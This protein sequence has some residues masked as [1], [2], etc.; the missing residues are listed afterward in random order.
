MSMCIV[1]TS[2]AKMPNS[3]WG[4]Y[5]RVAVVQLNQHYT[6]HGLRPKMISERAKGVLRVIDLGNHNVGKTDRCAWARKM[7]EAQETADRLNNDREIAAGEL[8]ITSA[9]A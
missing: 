6:A 4:T 5:R 7:R 8:L 9:C 1:M 3:C 2:S